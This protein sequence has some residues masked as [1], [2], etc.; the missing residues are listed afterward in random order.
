[1]YCVYQPYPKLHPRENLR[2][3]LEQY[4]ARTG[5]K[6]RLCMTGIAMKRRLEEAAPGFPE[7]AVELFDAPFMNSDDL[8]IRGE[9]E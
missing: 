8:Y 9:V 7:L 5:R 1:V 2:L 3:A 6:P 4:E